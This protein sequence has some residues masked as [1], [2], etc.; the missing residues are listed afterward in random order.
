MEKSVGLM[1]GSFN[2]PH[3]GHVLTA[4][5]AYKQASLSEVIM[6]PIPVSA[7]KK[8]IAQANFTE[9]VK[10]CEMIAQPHDWLS[11]SSAAEQFESGPV[12]QLQSLKRLVQHLGE[13]NPDTN[14]LLIG[15]NDFNTRIKLAVATLSVVN[16]ISHPRLG[17]SSIATPFALSIVDRIE[18]AYKTLA[19][20]SDLQPTQRSDVNGQRVSSS[21]IRNELVVGNRQ[22]HGLPENL[23]EYI[24]DNDIYS[25][26]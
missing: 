18:F 20:V 3:S 8:G 6:L 10:M 19:C 16:R 25:P 2:P 24:V 22:V 11:V 5:K 12:G 17:L 21:Y 15:G 7:T 13:E 4:S 14:Y 26:S 9:K 1:L 23:A